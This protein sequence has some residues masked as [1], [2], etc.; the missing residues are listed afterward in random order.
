MLPDVIVHSVN[1]VSIGQRADDGYI[2]STP[3]C[4]AAGKEWSGYR[5]LQSS[6]EFL[7][8]LSRSL[9]IHRDLLIQTITTGPNEQRGTWV[10]PQVAIHCAMWC[11]EEFASGAAR[12]RSGWPHGAAAAHPDLPRG[13]GAA[14]ALAG[15]HLYLKR[16][17][18]IS[19]PGPFDAI[20]LDIDYLPAWLANISVEAK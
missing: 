16:C 9:Q 19:L 5:R 11:S 1:N 7:E 8:A 10:H 20:G 17:A 2:N 15:R 14:G 6:E 18:S 4:Q 13:A 3:M 12:G